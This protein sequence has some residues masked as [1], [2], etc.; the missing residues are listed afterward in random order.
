MTPAIEFYPALADIPDIAQVL[1]KSTRITIPAG[2]ALFN[3]GDLCQ[4]FP[5]LLSGR[6][7]VFKQ[8]EN[9]REIELY[10]IHAGES[11]IITTSCLIHHTP[12]RARAVA[13][14][15]TELCLLPNDSFQ[16]GLAQPGF[17]HHILSLFSSR[18]VDL[19]ERVEEIAFHKLDARLADRLLGHGTD[20]RTTHA[21]LAN[22]LG[23]VREIISRLLKTFEGQGYIRLGR[24]HIEILNARALRRIADGG[25]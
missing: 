1:E 7:R 5:L 13:E 20:V 17:R 12:Y 16:L 6:V 3:E 22:E 21:Q 25:K 9:G 15:E 24:E 11:C 23:S 10:R 19:M 4:G 18:I 2:A 8:A 14:C